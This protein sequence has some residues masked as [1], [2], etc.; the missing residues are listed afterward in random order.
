MYSRA[1]ILWSIF[2]GMGGHPGMLS[3]ALVAVGAGNDGSVGRV[4]HGTSGVARNEQGR[5]TVG[6]SSAMVCAGMPSSEVRLLG[7]EVPK[8]GT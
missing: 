5:G 3:L 6:V 7:R 1:K 2:V 4:G 8:E